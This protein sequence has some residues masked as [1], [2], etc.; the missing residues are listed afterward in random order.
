MK[1][2]SNMPSNTSRLEGSKVWIEPGETTWWWFRSLV[3]IKLEILQALIAR[4][5]SL[6]LFERSV[7][8]FHW[9]EVEP[10][11]SM[12]VWHGF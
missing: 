8:G 4:A 11:L 7:T 12:T 1:N 10:I 6:S 5:N 9:E 2:N 3:H